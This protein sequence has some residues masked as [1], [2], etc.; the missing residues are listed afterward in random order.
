MW[1]SRSRAAVPPPTEAQF[2]LI[3]PVHPPELDSALPPASPCPVCG[4][5]SP[6]APTV[7]FAG[8][9]RVGITLL[10][11]RAAA[12]RREFTLI[13]PVYPLELDS[14]LVMGTQP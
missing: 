9:P 4:L 3:W 6:V 10:R 8:L 11:C 5:W 2:T 1:G 14:T 7:A 12:H 13:W